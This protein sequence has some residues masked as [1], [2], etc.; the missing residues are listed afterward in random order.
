MRAG[1]RTKA[2]FGNTNDHHVIWK[3]SLCP[4]RTYF[5][6]EPTDTR[7]NHMDSPHSQRPTS[8]DTTLMTSAVMGVSRKLSGMTCLA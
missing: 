6:S 7:K 5:H 3:G 2:V 1:G 8:A 4:D